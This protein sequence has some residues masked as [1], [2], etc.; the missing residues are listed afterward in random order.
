MQNFIDASDK[1][2]KT[3]GNCMDTQS[4]VC[5]NVGSRDADRDVV[6]TGGAAWW[7]GWHQRTL[8]W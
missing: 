1:V 2:V 8:P 6:L 5:D 3:H 4:A 7:R